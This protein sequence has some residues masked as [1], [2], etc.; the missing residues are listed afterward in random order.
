MTEE[1]N[2]GNGTAK[3]AGTDMSEYG[4]LPPHPLICGLAAGAPGGKV[5][6]ANE[7][8]AYALS[9]KPDPAAAG[10]SAG[11]GTSVPTTGSGDQTDPP[12][13]SGGPEE[14]PTLAAD[15][16]AF[17][18]PDR[19]HVVVF[20]GYL[21][22]PLTDPFPDHKS[23]NEWRLLYQDSRAISWLMVPKGA[24]VLHDRRRDNKAA[25]R[26]RDYIWVRADAP[27]RQGTEEES[28]QARFLV[29]TFTRAGDLHASL[30]E[31]RTSPA[32]SGIIC[33][34]TPECCP[35]HRSG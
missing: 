5:E 7:A 1:S 12:T 28:E 31:A 27:V 19:A 10:P 35:L 23:N 30:I 33:A 6:A 18:K 9:L 11:S 20:A 32:D 16:E 24:V 8:V 29:G 3:N 14:P 13:A 17:S 34:P 22:P 4:A 26:L 25:F 21:G 15:L 2:G